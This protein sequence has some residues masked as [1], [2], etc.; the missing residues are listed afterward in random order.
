MP[1]G[2]AWLMRKSRASRSESASQVTTLTPFSR[3]LRSTVEMATLFST[4]TA[5]ASTPRVIQASTT[6]FCFAG[7]RSV[8]P[9]HRSSTPSSFAASSAPCL[10]LM[11]YGSPFAFG[12]MAMTGLWP[13]AVFCAAGFCCDAAPPVAPVA[14]WRSERTR[15]QLLPATM[16]A[17]TKI[18]A[19]KVATCEFLT[20]S[21]SSAFA[22]AR[23]R[24]CARRDRRSSMIVETKSAPV[25]IPASSA[26]CALSRRPFRKMTM[27]NRPNTVPSTVP[28]P[29]KIDA[30]PSTTAAIAISS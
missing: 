8:G 7:S 9:S 26:G 21:S 6:S 30:P 24:A 5:M 20:S 14:P 15:S 1:C 27:A 25:S 22:R 3:A 18:T 29:P 17:A 4:L 12:I 10:Q 13:F 11:K 23:G 19:L 16:S 2:V 28:R